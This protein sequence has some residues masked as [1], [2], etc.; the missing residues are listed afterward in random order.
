MCVCVWSEKYE[1]NG[2]CFKKCILVMCQ[3]LHC[4][5]ILCYITWRIGMYVCQL[6]CERVY[7]KKNA[8]A[9]ETLYTCEVK[10]MKTIDKVQKLCFSDVQYWFVHT[11][12]SLILTIITYHWSSFMFWLWNRW[13]DMIVE[14]DSA[15]DF[16]WH[17]SLTR[18]R[19]AWFLKFVDHV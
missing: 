4:Q 19:G 1:D 7:L 2:K 13:S 17:N 3:V 9:F 8:A 6:F 10:N 16:F 15:F 11:I 5:D 14:I 18:A 12:T